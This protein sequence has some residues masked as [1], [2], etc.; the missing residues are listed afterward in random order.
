MIAGPVDWGP[1]DERGALNFIQPEKVRAAASLVRDGTVVSLAQPLFPGMMMP[2]HRAGM[3]HF[4]DRDGGDYAA[5]ARAPGGFK[6]SEDSVVMPL[7]IGTHV[8]A[9]CHCWYGDALYNG[10][11]ANEMRS[12]R[13]APRCGV[14]KIPPI[15]TRGVLLDFVGDGDAPEDG[16]SIGVDRVKAALD[17]AGAQVEP[18]DAI[19]L[20]TG[21]LERQRDGAKVDFNR[22][23]GIDLEAA[24]YLARGGS[25]VIGADNFAVEVLPFATGT[26]FPVHQRL[27]RDYGIPLMEGLVLAP[28]ARQGRG[29]F[30]F[31]AAPL[32]IRGGTGSPIVPIAI[33]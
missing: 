17:K 23:P 22:E 27:I 33:L 32:P 7:H 16:E 24:E 19:L 31:S 29:V 20:R 30:L 4:M 1:Q 9:L 26:V 12:T 11:P 25:A 28:L 6:F 13:G 2:E 15:V 10:F 3:M 21:W 14:D 18:G 8:D 5:G